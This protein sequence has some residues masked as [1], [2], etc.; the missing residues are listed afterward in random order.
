M[1]KRYSWVREK[2]D[3]K[4]KLREPVFGAVKPRDTA[5]IAPLR[6]S[7]PLTSATVHT[8][9][10]WLQRQT[11][12]EE[13]MTYGSLGSGRRLEWHHIQLLNSNAPPKRRIRTTRQQTPV[14][15]E[16]FEL[17]FFGPDECLHHHWP[18]TRGDRTLLSF[19]VG[20]KK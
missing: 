16:N 11:D 17:S 5:A 4:D 6:D 3:G 15:D 7:S 9:S 18:Y 19:N 14:Y 1:G 2:V 12:T 8:T 20:H 10:G 13:T